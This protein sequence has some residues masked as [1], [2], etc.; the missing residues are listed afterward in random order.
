[1]FSWV[2]TK[3]DGEPLRGMGSYTKSNIEIC[4]LGM[5]GHI[6]SADKTVP[7]ILM[8]PRIGHS[9]KPP[10]IRER[11]VQLFGNLTRIELF[12][13]QRTE[14]WDVVGFGVDGISLQEK[15]DT[16]LQETEEV[17]LHRIGTQNNLLRQNRAHS[18]QTAMS[19]FCI[20]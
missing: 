18:E 5:R 19:L 11:I 20:P 7:Q 17:Y 13:R 14:G 9:V 6:K 15:I 4:L 3:A 16:L 10:V 2:K 8:H 1:A 12:S